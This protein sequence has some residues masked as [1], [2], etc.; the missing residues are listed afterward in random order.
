ML[1][2]CNRHGISEYRISGNRFKCKKCEYI[3]TRK[4]MENLKIK[5]MKY[6]GG[7]CKKCGYDKCWKALHFHHLDSNL[8]EFSIFEGRPGFKKV[9]NWEQLKL[10]IDKCILLCAIC[11]IE[12]H[13]KD[14]KQILE[15]E[16]Q[17]NLNRLEIEQYNKSI[18]NGTKT[19]H[20][21]MD[22]ISRNP[23]REIL[24][25]PEEETLAMVYKKFIKEKNLLSNKT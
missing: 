10:E 3:Y 18:I 12:L 8:K 11:H 17:L 25:K 9:R 7:E 1:L 16:I 14:E 13:D 4:Y 6:G 2:I 20:E 19:A 23:K 21:C 15:K 22:I 24:H 5:A